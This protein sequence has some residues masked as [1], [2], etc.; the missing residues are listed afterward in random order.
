MG[1]TD[2]AMLAR[3]T[4]TQWSAR[5]TDRKI[6]EEVRQAHAASTDA[7]RYNKHLLSRAAL[8]RVQKAA[9]AARATH[10][11]LTLPW[12]DDGARILSGKGFLDYSRKM[13]EH[14][15]E[16]EAAAEEFFGG[17]D[18]FVND[19]RRRLNGMFR[20]E[21]YPALSRIR[22]KFSFGLSFDPLP[23]GAD[24]RVE[25]SDEEIETIR[26]DID[27]SVRAALAEALKDA[28]RR[29][30]DVTGTMAAKLADPDAIFRDSL[31]QNVR[32]LCAVLSGL[33]FADDAQLE[34]MRRKVEGTLCTYEPDELRQNKQTRQ[35]VADEAGALAQ[36]SADA[37]ARIDALG[38][39]WTEAQ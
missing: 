29:V 21:D 20:D 14:R 26:K 17:Y 32:D 24:F 2:K 11:A 36:A 23:T 4:I 35:R 33:N 37:M 6:T 30:Y 27:G 9:N 10:Y 7:G 39:L 28:W 15:I 8:E 3:L 16:F 31:V 12:R 38:A 25:L 18:D 13:R 34:E 19:D 1:L 5:K 22:G